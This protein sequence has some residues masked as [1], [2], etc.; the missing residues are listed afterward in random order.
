MLF[1]MHQRAYESVYCRLTRLHVFF[2]VVQGEALTSGAEE[3]F[4]SLP[5]S[6]RKNKSSVELTAM[7]VMQHMRVCHTFLC[8]LFAEGCKL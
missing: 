6:L 8:M 2:D 7:S 1:L 5:V 4:A 3:T